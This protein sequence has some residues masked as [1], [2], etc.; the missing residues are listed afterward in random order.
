M[1]NLVYKVYFEK[2]NL[3][4]YSVGFVKDQEVLALGVLPGET[5][6]GELKTINKKKIL[7]VKEIINPRKDRQKPFDAT[8]LST[9]PWQIFSYATQIN[10]KKS[11]IQGLFVNKDI[12]E[13]LPAD[14]IL[15]YRTK[16]EF[17]FD[18]L[19]NKV[20]LAF[21]DRLNK[22]KKIP[23][24]NFKLVEPL[25][26]DV[27]SSIL[28]W[29]NR[30]NIPAK[31]LKTLTLRQ[32]KKDKSVIGILLFK[33][34]EQIPYNCTD[35]SKIKN[36]AGILVGYSNP[37]SPASKVDE[38]FY[39]LGNLELTEKIGNLSFVYPYD[40]FF[41]NNLELF[42]KVLSKINDLIV[43]S[44]LF[45]ITKR[46]NPEIYS[47]NLIDKLA[48]NTTLNIIELYSGVGT[49][50]ISLCK[51]NFNIVGIDILESN[52]EYARINAKLNKCDNY[53]AICLAAEKVPDDYL[54]NTDVLIVDPSR[55]GLH[56][57][58]IKTILRTKPK[59][60]FYLSCNPSTLHSD[61]KLLQD[62]YVI[63]FLGCYDFY[64]N[65]PHIEVL[66]MLRLSFIK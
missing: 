54:K 32:S 31:S 21:F 38:V 6:I 23:V 55:P 61:I 28:K 2:V 14:E 58:L 63:D 27:A 37:K 13:F 35:L 44:V 64:P 20:I 19:N 17:S 62:Y 56:P 48:E 12:D 25:V 3:K 53:E 9:S 4:G 46:N 49:I 60:I 57:K 16:V 59:Y 51:R 26:M 39:Q 36:L 11:I 5:A 7:I 29:I 43:T 52:I 8:Y 47:H 30:N 50:G 40:G 1:N 24:D 41:Q 18:E 42:P 10:I 45:E 33:H 15:Y 22:Y 65:T 34:R 66:V